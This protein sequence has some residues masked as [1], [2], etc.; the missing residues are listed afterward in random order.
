MPQNFRVCLK[1]YSA[2][3]TKWCK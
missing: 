3:R 2:L 1:L